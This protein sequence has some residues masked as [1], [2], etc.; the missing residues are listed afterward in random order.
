MI[1]GVRGSIFD[2]SPGEIHVD[3]GYGI[4]LKVFYP[5][6]NF[7]QLKDKEKVVLHTVL[8]I[9]EEEV[10]LY[11]FLSKKEKMF[12][13]KLVS[14][15]GVGGKT[16]LSLISAFSMDELV[17]AINGGDITRICSIPGIG[18]KT[19]QRIVLELTGKLELE[20]D[21][22]DE[23]VKLK[24]DLISGLVN[25]GY[26]KKNVRH[27]VNRTISEIPKGKSFED[28]FKMLLKKISRL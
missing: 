13:E 22:V 5:V 11:G 17:E 26:S 27:F 12:F 20:V 9:K 28:L 2:I 1:S 7:S 15:S 8:K 21:Q 23:N 16:S 4:I 14:I 18:K 24:E 6:S 3:T 25:L 19:A 10:I